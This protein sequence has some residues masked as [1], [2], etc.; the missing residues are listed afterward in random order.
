VLGDQRR[1]RAH[2]DGQL[3]AQAL[4]VG[5]AQHL[6]LAPGGDPLGLEA[7]GPE[8]DRLRR[9]DAPHDGVHHAGAGTAGDRAR[10]LEERQL[11]ARPALLVGVEEV[12]H[13]RIVLVDRLG[14]EA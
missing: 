14:H 1:V 10:V 11:G 7:A 6:A 13:A 2:G 3:V 8:V 4:A 5:E 12:V 9:A